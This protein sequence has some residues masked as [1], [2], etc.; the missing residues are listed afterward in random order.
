MSNLN[1]KINLIW[2]IADKLRGAYKP[3]EYGKVILPFTVLRRF[4]CILEKKK[5]D[6]LNEVSKI[7]SLP[8]EIQ[9]AKLKSVS[10]Y[11]FYN[12]SEFNF[13][14]LLSDPNN[15]ESNLKSYI[16]G[17]SQN[18]IDILDNFKISAELQKLAENNILYQVVQEFSKTDMHPEVISNHDMGYVFEE[19]VRKFLEGYNAQA[20]EHYTPRE[21]VEL[22]VNVLFC[23]DKEMLTKD[24]AV[25]SIYDPACGTGGMLSVAEELLKSYNQNARLLMYGQEL[26]DET[27]AICK[28]DVLIKGSP[29]DNICKGNT[30]SD[31]KFPR[32]KFNYIISN[33]PFGGEWK[34]EKDAVERERNLG[35]DGRFSAGLPPI[36]DGQMLFLQTAISKMTP[37]PKGSRIAIIHNGS[38]LFT[39]D[40]GSGP[41]EIRR[42]ILESDLLEAII[43]L[44]NDIFYNT[45]IPT[46]IWILSNKKEQKRKGKV[47][48]INA[49]KMFVKMRKSL[50][51]KRNELS[52]EQIDEITRIYHDF[53][54]NKI[55]KIFNNTDF[56]YKKITIERPKRDENGEII[57]KKGKPQGDSELRD[58]ETIPLDADE[59]EY[60]KTEILPNYPDAWLD[61]DKTKIGYEI[62]FTR[63]FYEYV[64]P[65]KSDEIL[66]EIR[67]LDEKSQEIMKQ[68]LGK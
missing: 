11:D 51:N 15:I 16:E 18:V 66:S 47:Q 26:N 36:S 58:T 65:R 44:P 68:I 45:G 4:D 46:Y 23:N 25:R 39:G 35:T 24:S 14:K 42:H 31:D 2:S 64:A 22:M 40:A 29:A 49:N 13:I 20:G 67:E 17:F 63:H 37:P 19:V 28:A 60:F 12:T 59:N 61:T 48:L 38:P 27:F 33:P 9:T 30:L 6:V 10:G 3:H 53:E 1:E 43:A 55:S 21:V 41:S 5:S 7:Q 52:K 32:D 34:N 56:G 50:G 57:L 62:P 54:T 8:K